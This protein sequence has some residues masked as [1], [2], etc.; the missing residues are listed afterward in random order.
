MKNEKVIAELLGWTTRPDELQRLS[1]RKEEFYRE[2]V[3]QDGITPLPGVQPWLRAL[4]AAGIPCAVG[5]STPRLN[6]DCLID[7]LGLRECFQAIVS[8]EDVSHGKPHPE[9]F[10]RAAERL[11]TPPARCVVFEDAH[12]GIAA[13]LAAGMTVIAVATTHPAQTLGRAHRVVQRLDELTVPAVAE[14]LRAPSPMPA[15]CQ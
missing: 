4:R 9:V 7:T 13:G 3:R 10:L 1:W 14:C 8:A 15:E 2:R 11:D 6:I 5:S 12:V